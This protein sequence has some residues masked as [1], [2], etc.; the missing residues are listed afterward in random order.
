MKKISGWL[1]ALLVV[2]YSCGSDTQ[3]PE[4]TIS[5]PSDEDVVTL[6]TTLHF[7]SDFSDVSNLSQYKVQLEGVHQNLV[8]E[9]FQVWDTVLQ[10]G[11]LAGTSQFVH[12]HFMV[13]DTILPGPY[14]MTVSAL[15]E[16]GNE[17]VMYI[18]L[19]FE[20]DLD[21]R[22]PVVVINTPVSAQ[23]VTGT[24]A[25]DL[26]ITEKLSDNSTDGTLH[27]INASLFSVAT[28]SLY[29][30][31]GTFTDSNN[32]NGGYSSGTFTHTFTIPSN[33]TPDTYNL[34]IVARDIY[35]NSTTNFVQVTV[36]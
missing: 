26:S 35:Y 22:A 36:Q 3:G 30:D 23:T 6:G 11:S 8:N 5:E 14:L 17:T 9:Y 4:I 27:Y 10:V 29:F 7:E 32:F 12:E 15:D 18:N 28:P 24:I 34:V 19:T 16:L 1:L 25:V 20:K 2:F 13:P 31:L 33:V 21:T